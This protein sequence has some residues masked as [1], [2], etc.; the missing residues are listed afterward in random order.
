MTVLE[1]HGLD[2]SLLWC[3]LEI[4][5]VP[6]I[7]VKCQKI[8]HRALLGLVY[9]WV[10]QD[11]LPYLKGAPSAWSLHVLTALQLLAHS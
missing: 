7:V 6:H 9:A 1:P 5:R 4:L 10:L 8:V 11:C 2:Q 3:Q